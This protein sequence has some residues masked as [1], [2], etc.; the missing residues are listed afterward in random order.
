MHLLGK[1][2]F[3]SKPCPLPLAEHEFD[4]SVG[5]FGAGLGS[6][7]L[8]LIAGALYVCMG[9]WMMHSRSV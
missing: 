7:A 8:V 4:I 2:L 6:L 1:P 5:W 3:C 9:G